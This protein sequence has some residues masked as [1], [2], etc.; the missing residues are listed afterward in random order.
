M[1]LLVGVAALPPL[2]PHPERSEITLM[3][4]AKANFLVFITTSTNNVF[5]VRGFLLDVS[6]GTTA[7]SGRN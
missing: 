5:F 3:A 4:R 7:L 1:M 6:L 2:D